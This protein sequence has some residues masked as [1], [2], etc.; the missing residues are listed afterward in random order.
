[1]SVVSED[2]VDGDVLFSA[3]SGPDAIAHAWEH[4]DLPFGHH[5]TEHL[6]LFRIELPTVLVLKVTFRGSELNKIAREVTRELRLCEILATLAG[7]TQ[8]RAYGFGE[9]VARL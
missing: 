4:D 7:S 6:F 8:L 3:A 9:L 5:L 2:V 1:M